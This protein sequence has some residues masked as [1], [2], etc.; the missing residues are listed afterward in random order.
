MA[1]AMKPLWQ[2]VEQEAPDELIGAECH[3]A[4]PRLPVAAVILVAEAH[5]A[6]I[7]SKEA[8]VRDGDAMGVA[9]ELGK[10]CFWPGEGWLGV[11]EPVLPLKRCEAC[12]EGLAATQVLDL[13]KE[14][15][16]A[17]RVGVGECGQEEPP[18]QAGK[19]PHRQQEA[20]PA[21]HPAR[22]VDTLIDSRSILSVGKRA[23][24]SHSVESGGDG[25]IKS[26]RSG[27][28]LLGGRGG[29]AAFCSLPPNPNEDAGPSAQGRHSTTPVRVCHREW[30]LPGNSGP[31]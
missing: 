14:R 12:A 13:A 18:E 17:R 4:V 27:G 15:Q 2:N 22:S 7:E 29:L 10:H 16:P 25:T 1:D 6:R 23:S 28:Q 8:T 11:N 3:R 24:H 31:S 26:A 21:A 30:P 19:H 9:G 20:G 5:A